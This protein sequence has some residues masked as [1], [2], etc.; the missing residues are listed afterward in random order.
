M[1]RGPERKSPPAAT[2]GLIKNVDR[3]AAKN[4]KANLARRAPAD[5]SPR[6][7][8]TGELELPHWAR[9]DRSAS[10]RER[11]L[12]Y[13]GACNCQPF[14][15]PNGPAVVTSR[16]R[17]LD[18]RYV[19]ETERFTF[20]G[21][22]LPP[23]GSSEAERRAWR[24]ASLQR[25]ESADLLFARL[26]GIS[27]VV[28]LRRVEDEI[29]RA[30]KSV[31]PIF[32][33]VSGAATFEERALLR[34]VERLVKKRTDSRSLAVAESFDE[35]IFCWRESLRAPSTASRKRRRAAMS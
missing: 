32:L 17:G 31:V 34:R 13:E 5:N 23:P 28:E 12:G 25:L 15:V 3:R 14:D 20:L 21:P 8:I 35:A 11:L 18:P 24:K 10:W 2:G 16:S 29:R 22:W 7:F 1:R 27:E 4:D 26:G 6:I 30:A 33:H 9:A 19:I